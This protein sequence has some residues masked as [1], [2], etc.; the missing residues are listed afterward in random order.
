MLL[1]K[2]R[3]KLSNNLFRA[4]DQLYELRLLHWA[5]IRGSTTLKPSEAST[6]R[7]GSFDNAPS[8]VG[9]LFL[10][11]AARNRCCGI[12]FRKIA[13]YSVK[14]SLSGFIGRCAIERLKALS[15]GFSF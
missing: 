7:L 5:S 2:R 10:L 9:V 6:E 12:K 15:V 13:S 11:C 4:F 14:F 1:L 3:P 8:I